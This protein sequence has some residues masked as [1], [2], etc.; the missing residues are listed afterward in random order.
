ME[1]LCPSVKSNSEAVHDELT[2]GGILR[3]FLPVLL[4][5]L[6]LSAHKLR[7]LWQL[8]AC[9]TPAYWGPIFSIVHTASTGTRRLA[10]A[11]TGIVRAAWPPKAGNG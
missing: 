7:V 4:H 2:L 11:A 5:L 1:T 10:P 3:V 6:K 8:A 9:G